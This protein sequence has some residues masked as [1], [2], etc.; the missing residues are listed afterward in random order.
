MTFI[1]AFENFVT[2]W[3][4]WQPASLIFRFKCRNANNCYRRK[5]L[6]TTL[7]PVAEIA[8]RVKKLFMSLSMVMLWPYVIAILRTRMIP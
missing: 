3:Q 7:R 5:N 8:G 1:T 2:Y 4:N 6:V